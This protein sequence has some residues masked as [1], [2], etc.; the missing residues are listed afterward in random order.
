MIPYSTEC[1]LFSGLTNSATK[2]YQVQCNNLL[3]A[4]P[5]PYGIGN[6]SRIMAL[7]SSPVSHFSIL[8]AYNNLASFYKLIEEP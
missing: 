4:M 2:V 8:A 1:L 5:M 3:F 7:W 6:L